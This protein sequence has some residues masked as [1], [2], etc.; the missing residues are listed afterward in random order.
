[1]AMRMDS[2]PPDVSSPTASSPCSRPVH[3]E[4]I[5]ASNLR[6]DGKTPGYSAFVE[7]YAAT[8]PD[9]FKL[10]Q[11]YPNPFNSS[12]IIRVVLPTNVEVDLAVYNLAGQK[13]ATLVAGARQAGTYTL[14]WDGHDDGG[15]E[16]ASGAYLYRLR[17]GERMEPRKMLLLR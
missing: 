2:V 9:H 14:H 8:V 17:A 15:R 10:Q 11:N 12:T 5:S 3:I 6:S 1:M 16:L 7:A 4:M 13:V